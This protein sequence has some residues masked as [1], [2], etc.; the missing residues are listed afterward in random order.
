MALARASRAGNGKAFCR[1]TQTL[2]IGWHRQR[3]VEGD[4]Y[5]LLAIFVL[6]L[7]VL[8]AGPATAAAEDLPAPALTLTASPSTITSGAK[9]TL[10]GQLEA[11]GGQLTLLRQRVGDA[12]PT[13]IA[14]LSTDPVTGAFTRTVSPGRTATFSVAY[15]GDGVAW[16]PAEAQ[17]LVSVRPRVTLTA[18]SPV[19]PGWKVELKCAVAPKHAGSTVRLLLREADGSWREW[20]TLTLNAKSSVTHVWRPA[21]KGSYVFK[22]VIDEHDDHLLGE[23]VNR[24]VVVRDGNPYDVPTTARHFIVVDMSEYKLYYHER[25]RVVRIFKCVLGKPSTPTPRVKGKVWKRIAGMWGP[26]GP[27][28]MKY[29]NNY[30]IHGTNQPW[31]LDRFPRAYSNGCTRLSNANV[32]WLWSR[33][34]VGTP[35]WNVP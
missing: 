27:Y 32:T 2:T 18:T 19:Y 29:H 11:P 34:P 15:E 12:Q 3:V 16:G 9:S 20:R 5:K 30:A 26:Y 13:A 8:A 7:S 33:A 35:V 17:V 24:K 1:P 25:G 4:V 28:T 23:S 22:A 31:L 6:A 14:T 21:K 10:S